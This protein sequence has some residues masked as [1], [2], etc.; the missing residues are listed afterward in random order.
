M[1][2]KELYDKHMEIYV[3][4]DVPESYR[5]K[6][7]ATL[8]KDNAAQLRLK[9][10]S[11]HVFSLPIAALSLPTD[12]LSIIEKIKTKILNNAK[13]F[14]FRTAGILNKMGLL[15]FARQAGANMILKAGVINTKHV[16]QDDSLFE[17]IGQTLIIN[18]NSYSK[19]MTVGLSLSNRC[20]L[21]CQMCPY[22]GPDE[23]LLHTT[24][25]FNEKHDISKENFER[26]VKYCA[27]NGITLQLG[28]QDEPLLLLFREGYSEILQKYQ[29]LMTLTT[30]GTLLRSEKQW[31]YLAGLKHLHHVGISIDGNSK[32]VYRKIRGDNL[33]RLHKQLHGFFGYIQK[34]RPDIKRRVCF[35]EQPDNLHEREAFLNYWKPYVNQISFYKLTEFRDDELTFLESNKQ[36]KRTPCSAIFT[37]MYL[38][39]DTKVQPCC[40]FMYT[41]PYVGVNTIAEFSEDI[42][43]S[44]KYQKFRTQITNED[45]GLVC[46][47]CTIWRQGKDIEYVENNLRVSENA[48]EKHYFT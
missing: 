25:Y 18:D 46:D 1:S 17:Y 15:G 39:P 21:A 11:G 8:H 7:S 43:K 44:E 34:H 35:V 13:K 12:Q 26:V 40:L 45:F 28:Q 10:S 48:Y 31:K 24:N 38:M 27:E 5:S 41:A 4:R 42:W 47:K 2:I 3:L 32:E 14:Y 16:Y 20:N 6:I 30:N 37:T 23:K 9:L 22:H 36:K 19:P 29:P 33:E